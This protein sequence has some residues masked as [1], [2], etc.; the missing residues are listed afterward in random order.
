MMPPALL[1]ERHIALYG[2]LPSDMANSI[3]L[4]AISKMLAKPHQATPPKLTDHSHT[5]SL[6]KTGAQE[7]TEQKIRSENFYGRLYSHP[8]K[9]NQ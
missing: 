6:Q 1:L 2:L 9:S 4:L 8:M 7:Q 3:E 5:L